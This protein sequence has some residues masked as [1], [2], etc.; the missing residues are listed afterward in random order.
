MRVR[1]SLFITASSTAADRQAFRQDVAALA[2]A[3]RSGGAQFCGFF[4]ANWK[5][6]VFSL[7]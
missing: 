6:Q 5:N 1:G 2:K 3:G 7:A 4:D